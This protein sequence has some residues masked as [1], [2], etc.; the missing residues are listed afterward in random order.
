MTIPLLWLSD[1][2]SDS[3]QLRADGMRMGYLP[4][5][6]VPPSQ[7]F[8][9]STG[10]VNRD[11]LIASY[12]PLDRALPSVVPLEVDFEH[13]SWIT[14][15]DGPIDPYEY[16]NRMKSVA[17]FMRQR[18]PNRLISNWG[19]PVS[20][21]WMLYEAGKEWTCG[22]VSAY[23]RDGQQVG[24][25]KYAANQRLLHA[26]SFQ[27]PMII[28]VSPVIWGMGSTP[29][30]PMNTPRWETHVVP[31]IVEKKPKY[32]QFWM[33]QESDADGFDDSFIK[34]RMF[35]LIQAIT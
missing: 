18:Y 4:S 31:Y 19:A 26:K 9:H 23:W 6:F 24:E 1:A 16:M 17:L 3:A 7:Y 30:I 20:Q 12:D 29:N 32:V 25:W 35:H 27:I 10:A 22:D 14:K 15:E 33:N 34:D 21:H 8:N 5:G 11:G 13:Q 2:W 28:S